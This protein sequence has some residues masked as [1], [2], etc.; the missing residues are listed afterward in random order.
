M[1]TA[2]T[3]RIS[4]LALAALAAL[5]AGMWLGWSLQ[6]GRLE[7]ARAETAAVRADY[8]AKLATGEAAARLVLE[9]ERKRA[10]DANYQFAIKI[11]Q[12]DSEYAARP[13]T[14]IRVRVPR[15]CPVPAPG[16][17]QADG[18]DAPDEATPD[19]SG[20]GHDAG[21]RYLTL[22]GSGFDTLTLKAK[23]VSAQLVELQGLCK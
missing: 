10:D 17:D 16:A 6:S 4:P 21:G 11:A 19:G 9:R 13:P 20:V 5:V 8:A 3:A 12:L 23:K 22:D 15:A 7:K 1:W 14:V 18:A 2:I